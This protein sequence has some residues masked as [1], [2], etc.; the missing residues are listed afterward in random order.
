MVNKFPSQYGL[1]YN[2][3]THTRSPLKTPVK[4]EYEASLVLWKLRRHHCS[5]DRGLG[6]SEPNDRYV[7]ANIMIKCFML[8]PCPPAAFGIFISSSS[9]FRGTTAQN[10]FSSGQSWD[11]WQTKSWLSRR[12]AHSTHV[13]KADCPLGSLEYY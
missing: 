12:T 3:V 7:R 6:T 13:A 5:A 8:V 2:S 11:M 10:I 4:R 9:S 1:C